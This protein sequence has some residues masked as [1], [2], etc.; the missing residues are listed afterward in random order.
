MCNSYK[1]GGNEYK[2]LPYKLGPSNICT[3]IKNDDYFYKE[4]HSCT[5]NFPP[6]DSCEFKKGVYFIKNYLPDVKNLPPVFQSGD[7]M[8][9]CLLHKGDELIQGYKLFGQLYNIPSAQK[10]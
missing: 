2:L 6:L 3:I 1:K 4:F 8:L 10:F 9:E 5:E 7:Y